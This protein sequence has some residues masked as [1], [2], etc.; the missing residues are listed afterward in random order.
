MGVVVLELRLVILADRQ[1]R[2]ACRARGADIPSDLRIGTI[3][4]AEV[5]HRFQQC[6]LQLKF[7]T[8]T[9]S[10]LKFYISI[11][12]SIYLAFI[13][14]LIL[15]QFLTFTSQWLQIQPQV[16]TKLSFTGRSRFH[17]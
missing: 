16:N 15:N 7:K 13:F 5:R 12:F 1:A 17:T 3:G 8:S 11:P 10:L 4:G 2:K 14:I 9:S 6:A